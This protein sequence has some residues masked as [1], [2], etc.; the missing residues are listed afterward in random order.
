MCGRY[1]ITT[2]AQA[3]MDAYRISGE[4]IGE[5]TLPNYNAA[6]SQYLPIIYNGN[7]EAAHWGFVPF[8]AKDKKSSFKM[9]NAR[10]E[11][12][13]EKRLYKTPIAKSRCIVPATGW[14]EWRK[15]GARKQPYVFES[16]NIMSLAGICTWHKEF[17]LRSFSIITTHANAA[18]ESYHHRMPVVLS[19]KQQGMWLDPDT[20]L[21]RVT[22]ALIPYPG[23]DLIIR[24]VSKRLGN[25]RNNT[26]DLL[27]P[28]GD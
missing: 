7:L 5:F 19:P 28:I 1:N 13:T 11:T 27:A 6:P 16:G 12:I 15:E 20:E 9:I 24:K 18:A 3:L 8:L 26:D 4:I 23:D 10:A 25:V 2:D 14:Y 21:Q 22:D 17:E